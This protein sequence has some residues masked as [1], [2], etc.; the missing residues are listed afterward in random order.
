MKKTFPLQGYLS[1]SLILFLVSCGADTPQQPQN[2]DPVVAQIIAPTTIVG[3]QRAILQVEASDPDGDTLTFAWEVSGGLIAGKT[4][5]ALWLAPNEPGQYTLSVTVNDGKGGVVQKSVEVVVTAPEFKLGDL[6][7]VETVNFVAPVIRT[8]WAAPSVLTADQTA[9]VTVEAA[10]PAFKELQYSWRATGGQLLPAPPDPGEVEGQ[11][12]TWHPPK[13]PGTYTL[14]VVVFND[15]EEVEASI[16]VRVLS[17][18]AGNR[19]P[20]IQAFEIQPNSFIEGGRGDTARFT[21]R[22]L[23]PDGDALT[24][25]WNRLDGTMTVDGERAQWAPPPPTSACCNFPYTVTV[26]LTVSDGKGG[27]DT[28]SITMTVVP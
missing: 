26:A 4:A 19:P 28:S 12:M 22:A 27:S 11:K 2:Q 25:F 21:V 24:Y 13:P 18:V 17:A 6:P 1:F 14:T 3:G 15:L 8:L 9:A 16:P 5:E 7:P 23:D 10:D 20:K